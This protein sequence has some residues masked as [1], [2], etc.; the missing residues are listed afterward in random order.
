MVPSSG[1]LLPFS[2]TALEG[3]EPPSQRLEQAARAPPYLV[4]ETKV[5]VCPEED[6]WDPVRF[7]GGSHNTEEGLDVPFTPRGF[8]ITHYVSVVFL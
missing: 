7:P 4:G 2:V 5:P 3:R 1:G 6:L 8:F